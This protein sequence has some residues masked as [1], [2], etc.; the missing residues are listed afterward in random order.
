MVLAAVQ[1]ADGFNVPLMV[2]SIGFHYCG[3]L[4]LQTDGSDALPV[5]HVKI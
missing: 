1:E 4:C 3:G 5:V 2:V